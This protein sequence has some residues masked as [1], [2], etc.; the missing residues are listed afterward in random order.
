[1][2]VVISHPGNRR[3]RKKAAIRVRILATAIKLFSQHGLDDV[4][5]EQI[6]DA[7]DI[8]KG[9]IYNYFATKEDIVVAFMAD[10]E[11]RVQAKVRRSAASQ[12]SLQSI[13]TK[14]IR[15]QFR[16]KRPYHQFVRVFLGH[17]FLRTEQFL[18]NMVEMQKAVDPPLEE[19]FLR[20]QKRGL[21]RKDVDLA[22]LIMIFKTIHL[23]LSALWT[24]E[25]PPFRQTEKI[26]KREIKLFCEGLRAR[27]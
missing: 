21:M 22:E 27:T 2:T 4:T 13:L 8:G 17:M 19:L 5:V 7:A 1:M 14:F 6:A 18:P 10:M 20:L 3:E 15:L 23:G 25:G 12:G 24:I 16:L 9:T 11:T 26:L